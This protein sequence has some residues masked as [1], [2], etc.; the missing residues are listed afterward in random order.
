MQI[1]VAMP[2]KEITLYLKASD[3]I[4][5]VKE[6]IQETEGIPVNRQRLIYGAYLQDGRTLSDY[7]IQEGATLLLY[8]EAVDAV[9][10]EVQQPHSTS[11]QDM[12]I[13]IETR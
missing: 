1:I 10:H 12:N 8:Q 6:K 13:H 4:A 11:I 9:T 2:D 3:T 7:E 5:N